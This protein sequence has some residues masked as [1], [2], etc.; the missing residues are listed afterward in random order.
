M[1]TTTLLGTEL[2]TKQRKAHNVSSEE[3]K[4]LRIGVNGDDQDLQRTQLE[5]NLKA[6]RDAFTD[7]SDPYGYQRRKKTVSMFRN[8]GKVTC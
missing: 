7:K 4:D 1:A 6:N 5:A 2:E 3:L 8:R